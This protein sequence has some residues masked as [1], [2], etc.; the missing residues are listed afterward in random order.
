MAGLIEESTSSDEH[1]YIDELIEL[2]KANQLAQEVLVKKSQILHGVI[3]SS[4]ITQR[5]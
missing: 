2:R 1:D 3:N 5:K 4:S